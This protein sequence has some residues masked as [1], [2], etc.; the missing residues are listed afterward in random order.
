MITEKKT[1]YFRGSYIFDLLKIDVC[2]LEV[3]QVFMALDHFIFFT[4]CYTMFIVFNCLLGM[5]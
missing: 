1:L 5:V 4:A 2:F 3:Y